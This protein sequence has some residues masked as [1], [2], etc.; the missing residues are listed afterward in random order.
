MLFEFRGRCVSQVFI[1][2]ARQQN[3]LNSFFINVRRGPL[4]NVTYI[5]LHAN[6]NLV[7]FNVGLRMLIFSGQIWSKE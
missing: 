4:H 2:T 6:A 7:F 3:Q 5:T 1:A